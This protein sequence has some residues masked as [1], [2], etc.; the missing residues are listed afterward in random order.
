RPK[1]QRHKRVYVME[2]VSAEGLFFHRSCFQCDY[3][4]S[5]LRLA[6]YAYD[7][8]SVYVCCNV[9]CHVSPPAG[10]G[11]VQPLGDGASFRS[12]APDRGG[13]R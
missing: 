3:C 9:L 1:H 8:H 6:A 11:G 13:D 12:V 5:T 10:R 4:S 7:Q 2:R